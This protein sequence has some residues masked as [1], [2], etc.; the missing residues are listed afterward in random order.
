MIVIHP[1]LTLRK[2]LNCQLWDFLLSIADAH[3]Q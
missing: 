1:K 2:L 3:E